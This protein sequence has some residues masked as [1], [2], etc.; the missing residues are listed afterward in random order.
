MSFS[1]DWP[2]WVTAIATVVSTGV[3]YFM[4]R[5]SQ[6][7]Y[8]L[9]A[10]VEK[11]KEAKVYAWFQDRKFLT[12]TNLGKETLPIRQLRLLKDPSEKG[13]L[14][15]FFALSK[16]NLDGD[17]H[18]EENYYAVMGTKMIEPNTPV[19]LILKE[20]F[21]VVNLEARYFDGTTETIEIKSGSKSIL[22]GK[23]K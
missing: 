8:D 19:L 11:S 17:T 5:V 7:L 16:L 2:A 9:Q 20:E 14:E 15:I 3:A 4:W 1:I 22:K 6:K 23:G 13:H 18:I 21:S 12:L 10:S